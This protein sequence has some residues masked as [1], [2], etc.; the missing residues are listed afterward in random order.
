MEMPL[1][2]LLVPDEARRYWLSRGVDIV[3]DLQARHAIWRARHHLDRTR[4]AVGAGVDVAVVRDMALAGCGAHE[5]V[6]ALGCGPEWLDLV[7]ERVRVWRR[8]GD[9]L[10]GRAAARCSGPAR[11]AVVG[12]VA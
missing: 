5:I 2:P 12:E 6:D 1:D 8:H 10:V 3:A 4:A 7:A 9:A 11:T